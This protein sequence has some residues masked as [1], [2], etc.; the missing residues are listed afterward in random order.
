MLP[1]IKRRFESLLQSGAM[2]I[3]GIYLVIGLAWIFFS[4]RLAFTSASQYNEYL[5]FS[6]FKGFL[7]IIV[8]AILL[9][10]MIVFYFRRVDEERRR[11]RAL[12]ENSPDMIFH[13]SLPDGRFRYVSPSSLAV[14]GYAP[15][16]FIQNP[17]L[18]YQIIHPAWQEFF[19]TFW[20]QLLAG[21]L[22]TASEYQIIDKSGELRWVNQRSTVI[23]NSDG[24]PVAVEGAIT[25]LTRQKK[26]EEQINLAKRKL[27]LM[28]DITYQDIQN[29]VTALRGYSQ[30]I[31]DCADEQERTAFIRKEEEVLEMI[32]TL[33]KKTKDYQQMGT[34]HSCWISLEQ[35]IPREWSRIS[36]SK[37]SV[38]LKVHVA[39]VEIY[40][41]PLFDRV[42]YNLMENALI[43]G[44]KVSR[45]TFTAED[46]P[47]GLV[48]VCG[49]DGI[50][51][52][53]E[54]KSRLFDRVVAGGKFGLFFVAEFLTLS[55]ITIAETGTAGKG[56]RFEMTVP[57]GM[58]RY[59]AGNTAGGS[60]HSPGV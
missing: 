49:D 3:A 6:T 40:A 38:S 24:L 34:D 5:L 57:K 12:A 29:K 4:D 35:A 23:R 51:I 7:F 9:Y 20:E 58:Y 14:S 8:T 19:R 50:G 37:N 10:T 13:L 31:R 15:E 36:R 44:E 47:E 55:G 48:L 30:L 25:D 27:A 54:E 42:L 28:S 59:P 41:D 22:S 60:A 56:A 16:E 18:V 46:T 26:A 21:E 1:R 53:R 33:I 32:H 43:H 17:G 52:A 11:Y 2:T 45:V 39:G